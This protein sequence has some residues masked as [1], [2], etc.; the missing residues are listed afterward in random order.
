MIAVSP[1]VLENS[2]KKSITH[3]CGIVAYLALLFSIKY[4]FISASRLGDMPG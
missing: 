4:G 1:P 3:P 2:L